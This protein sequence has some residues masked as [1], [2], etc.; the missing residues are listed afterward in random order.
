MQGL[1]FWINLTVISSLLGLMV[2]AALYFRVRGLPEGNETM[3]RIAGYIREGAMAFLVAEY[4]VLAVY[5]V[6]VFGALSVA[7]SPMAGA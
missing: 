5:T 4:K 1:G 3:S 7:L 6:V 2:A